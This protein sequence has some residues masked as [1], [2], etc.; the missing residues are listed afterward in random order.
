[1]LRSRRHALHEGQSGGRYAE[2]DIREAMGG[3]GEEDAVR[4]YPRDLLRY[5]GEFI[6]LLAAMSSSESPSY[7]TYMS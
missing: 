4:G 1:M 2:E 3:L 7:L 5:L 6:P